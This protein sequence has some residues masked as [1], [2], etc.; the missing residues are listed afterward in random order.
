MDSERWVGGARKE[1]A[2]V[3]IRKKRLTDLF[4]AE[5]RRLRDKG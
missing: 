1:A 4:L 3:L 5:R 2:S